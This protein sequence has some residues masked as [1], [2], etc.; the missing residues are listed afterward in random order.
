MFRNKEI[1]IMSGVA[2]AISVA[3]VLACM[4]LCPYVGAISATGFL[5]LCISFFVFTAYRYREIA[6][7][8]SYLYKIYNGDRVLDIRNSA[9]GELGILKSDIYKITVMLQEKTDRLNAEQT[10]LSDALADISHQLNTPI[11]G[12]D[13]LAQIL[14][15]SD[16][17]S[18][19]QIKGFAGRISTLLQRMSWLVN[20]LL[21]L[22]KIDSGTEKFTLKENNLRQLIE[23]CIAPVE[24]EADLKNIFIKYSC[25]EDIT[26]VFDENW[27]VQALSN[28]VKNCIEHTPSGKVVEIKC[29]KQPLF[30]TIS[31]CDG[32]GGIDKEDIPYIFQRFYKGKNSK[33]DSVGIGLA[34]SKTVLNKQGFSITAENKDDGTCFLITLYRQ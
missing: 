30:T 18:C 32:G 9:D 5:L 10:R 17:L 3:T 29:K 8:S 13:A 19:E 16:N 22:S 7:L 20:I 23:K 12:A 15:D 24:L 1:R 4:Q 2:A 25:D 27:T 11:T 34:F 28:I 6:K 33:N 14:C 31:I 26:A 21:K